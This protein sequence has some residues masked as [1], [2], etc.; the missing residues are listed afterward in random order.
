MSKWRK[1]ID[2][3]KGTEVIDEVEVPQLE[4]RLEKQDVYMTSGSSC[5]HKTFDETLRSSISHKLEVQDQLLGIDRCLAVHG[6]YETARVLA[7][8][9]NLPLIYEMLQLREEHGELDE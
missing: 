5:L 4:V 1:F 8:R 9:R 2:R 3:F 6:N 7:D